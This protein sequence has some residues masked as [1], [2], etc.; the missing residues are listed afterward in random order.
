MRRLRGQLI[1]MMS[2]IVMLTLSATLVVTL[3]VARHHLYAD[4]LRQAKVRAQ[5]FAYRAAFATLVARDDPQSPRTLLKEVSAAPGTLGTE[6]V[7][8]QG[9]RLAIDETVSNSIDACGFLPRDRHAR[10]GELGFQIARSWCVSMPIRSGAAPDTG[11]SHEQGKLL[12]RLHVASDT[13]DARRVLQ[14]LLGSSALAG[15]LILGGGLFLVVRAASKASNPLLGIVET[16][17][18]ARKGKA[19]ARAVPSGPDEVVTI[20]Q[21]YN[22]LMD[23]VD[24]QSS[25]LEAQ[26]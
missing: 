21:V 19:G 16:M 3:L 6:L 12:G 10:D 26:V 23:S 22:Q 2:G 5:A 8:A 4:G 18:H 24:R 9:I 20:A 15:L 11:Q 1:A 25:E 7:D 13:V 17:Q 14:H